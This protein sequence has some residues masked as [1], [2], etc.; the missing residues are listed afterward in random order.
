MIQLYST[1]RKANGSYRAFIVI[2]FLT[3]GIPGRRHQS[4]VRGMAAT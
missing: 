4:C 1:V 3:F 2:N